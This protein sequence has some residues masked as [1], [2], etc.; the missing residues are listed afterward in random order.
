MA[1]QR[2]GRGLPLLRAGG[3]PDDLSSVLG[4]NAGGGSHQACSR[5]RWRKGGGRAELSAARLKSGACQYANHE[6]PLARDVS[7]AIFNVLLREL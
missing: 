5:D 4:S 7:C 2:K 1:P 3:A 6:G